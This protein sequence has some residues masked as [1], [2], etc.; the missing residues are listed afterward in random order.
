[1]EKDGFVRSKMTHGHFHDVP[2]LDQSRLAVADDAAPVSAAGVQPCIH[3]VEILAAV[4]DFA[5]VE[6]RS[7][8][9]V[10]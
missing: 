9:T 3:E 5:V 10:I 1:M 2:R 8:L 4:I 6:P 7:V